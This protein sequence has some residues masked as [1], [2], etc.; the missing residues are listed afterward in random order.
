MKTAGI[1][2]PI[3]DNNLAKK[4]VVVAGPALIALIPMAAVPALPAMAAHFSAGGDGA[5]FAQMVMT[6]PAV[7]LILSATVTG[8]LA[9]VV[10]RRKVL[11]VA[12]VLFAVAGVAALFVPSASALIASRL[13]LG[14]AGGA[15]LTT[16]FALA[17]DYHGAARERLLGYAGAGS[18]VAAIVALILGG[19]LVDMFGWRGPFILYLASLVVFIVALGAVKAHQRS[20]QAH[21]S[22]SAV[23]LLW[24]VLLLTI[25]LVI[26]I[27]MPGIQGPFLLQVEGVTSA[28]TQGGVIA[29]S[30]FAA[31]LAAASFGFLRRYLSLKALLILTAA[32]MGGGSAAM[33]LLHGPLAIA[34]G[35]AVVGIGAG[36]VEPIMMTIVMSRAPKAMHPRAVGMLLSAVFLGQF[37]NPLLLNPLRTAYGIHQ[38]FFLVGLAFLLMAAIIPMVGTRTVQPAY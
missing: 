21:S 6:V 34:L 22:G 32:S 14:L 37:L 26:G 16:S 17:G 13:V 35:F 24:P 15:I 10:D 20:R 9:E 27:F 28:A 5:F 18:A 33:L 36:L 12:L 7:L 25:L 30:S 2:I 23:R 3:D 11:L 1:A 19:K 29:A 31:A 8:F 4:F 38:V